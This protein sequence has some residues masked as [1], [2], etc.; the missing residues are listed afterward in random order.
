MNECRPPCLE[1]KTVTQSRQHAQVSSLM[2]CLLLSAQFVGFNFTKK[3]SDTASSC[4]AKSCFWTIVA[5]AASSAFGLTAKPTTDPVNIDG[6]LDEAA[7]QQAM[8]FSDFVENM[9]REKQRASIKSQ[10]MVLYDDRALYFG[11]RAYDNDPSSIVAPIARH[12]KITAGHDSFSVWIDPTGAR[13]FAQVFR[14]SAGGATADGLWNEYALPEDSSPDYDFEAVARRL[15]DGWSAEIA[16]PWS[17]L[18]ISNAPSATMNVLVFRNLLR[19]TRVRVSNAP[20]GRDPACYL[21]VADAL[22]GLHVVP[23]TKSLTITPSVASTISVN[24]ER[25]RDHR[26]EAGFDVKWRPSA[27]WF[28]DGT[29][30]PDFSQV[31]LD[32]PQLKSNTRFALSFPEKRPFF[33]EGTDLLSLPFATT[34]TRSITAPL[35][36]VRASYR[37]EQADATALAVSDRGG[38]YVI[39]PGT[40]SSDYR[41][42]PASTATLVRARVPLRNQFGSGNVGFM[43]NDRTYDDGSSNRVASI[44]GV[45]KPADTVRIRGQALASSATDSTGLNRGFAGFA[46]LFYDTGREYIS[47]R[48]QS[49]SPKFRADSSLVTQSGYHSAKLES[50]VCNKLTGF[51]HEIC[52]GIIAKEAMSWDGKTISRSVNPTLYLGGNRNSEWTLRP[53]WLSYQRVTPLGR[54]HYVPTT[55]VQIEADPNIFLTKVSFDAEAGRAVDVISDT[56]AKLSYFGLTA[57]TAILDNVE[58]EWSVS[59]YHLRDENTSSRRL[60][61][62]NV[63]I[64]AV[65]HISPRDTLRF[66]G[67]QSTTKRNPSAYSFAVVPRAKSR[68]ASLIYTRRWRL[69]SELNFGV[70]QS[71]DAQSRISNRRDI[72][73]FTKLSWAFQF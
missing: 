72:E 34:Y 63:Q 2:K 59:D 30:R 8:P 16:I 9:P 20:L 18:R 36:G 7:W 50:Y 54:L 33:L 11:L 45:F 51:F 25:E 12:D 64:V 71:S 58:I 65:Q 29:F 40:Y 47:I 53:R 66:V 28:L 21:C 70:T 68:A 27:S 6:S 62:R 52:P 31:A 37:T 3:L 15:S 57:K 35:W 46:D 41:N 4:V 19:D 56:R 14:I 26:L 73:I 32:A 60:H 55:Y 1:P 67:Q 69:D 22:I 48:S 49:V 23:A 24:L 43:L 39:L 5:L 61:E 17:T 38:G 13:Q 44:D 10:V 42:Q